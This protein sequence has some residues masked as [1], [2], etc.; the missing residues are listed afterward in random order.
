MTQLHRFS[1]LIFCLVSASAI[2]GVYRWVDESGKVHY[3]DK[4]VINSTPVN[5][6]TGQPKGA[7]PLPEGVDPATLV[8]P[9]LSGLTPEQQA[10]RLADC[11]Q[12][13]KQMHGYK[14]ASRI[15]ETDSL[16][17][18]HEFTEEERQLLIKKTEKDLI[19]AGCG[20]VSD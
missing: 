10:Q 7:K 12:K 14:G 11:E 18:E 15:V 3:T 2:A 4:P 13:K 8:A 17:R 20:T 9:D 1:A 16:G 5:I 6:N 19:E